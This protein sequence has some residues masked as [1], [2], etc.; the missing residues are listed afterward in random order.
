MEH[1]VVDEEVMQLVR[2]D[3]ILGLLLDLAFVVAGISSGLIG[4]STMS[5]NISAADLP[6]DAAGD[7]NTL[8]AAQRTRCLI[9]VLG[10]EALTPYIDMWSPLYVHQP[11]ASSERSPVPTTRP[12]S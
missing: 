8:A 6:P 4:V 7:V 11:R 3:E 5:T 12:F 2:S 9:K 10:T 1:E